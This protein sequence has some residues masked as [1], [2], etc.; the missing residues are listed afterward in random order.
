VSLAGHGDAVTSASFDASGDTVLTTS[1]NGRARLW[2]SRVRSELDPVTNVPTPITTASFSDDG[3]VAAV[4]GPSG[5]RVLRAADGGLIALLPTDRARSLALNRD[6][7]LVAARD[8]SRVSVW[9]VATGESAGTLDTGGTTTAIAISPDGS[10]VAAGIAGGTIR[11]WTL[12]DRRSFDLDAPGRGVRSI[13][14]NSSGD[15][16]VAGL[17]DGTI[18]AWSTLDRR[19]LYRRLEHRRASAVRS[20]AFSVGDSRLVTAGRDSTVRVWNAGTGQ[21]LFALRG[22]FGS[23]AD[24]GFSADGQWVVTAGPLTA[25]LWDLASRQRLLFLS[26]HEGRL[27]AASFDPAGSTITTV[28]VDGVRS[29]RCEVCGS[30][31]DLLQLAERRLAATGRELTATERRRYLDGG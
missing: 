31:A 30:V 19:R 29:Y 6:G 11:V 21:A 2:S 15:R 16:L 27:L 25:G 4:A 26:G 28:G 24:A 18:A 17:E 8:G 23:V 9:R 20:V 14:F 5:T 7:S 13:A 22:H 10:R 12:G 3:S 1:A